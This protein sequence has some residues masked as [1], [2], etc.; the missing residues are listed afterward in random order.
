MSWWAVYPPITTAQTHDPYA[1]DCSIWMQRFFG[2]TPRQLEDVD[3]GRP[4]FYTLY[5]LS[6]VAW[7]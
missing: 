5:G 6:V 4:S 3:T 2:F 1:Q 7:V